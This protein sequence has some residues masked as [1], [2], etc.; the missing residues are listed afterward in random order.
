MKKI[1][2]MLLTAV[3]LICN[4]TYAQVPP[5]PNCT[6]DFSTTVSGLTVNFIP[7]YNTDSALI[8]HTWNFGDG[9]SPSNLYSPSHTY[10]GP[11]TYTIVHTIVKRGTTSGT[12]ACTNSMTK[13]VS[14]TAPAPCNLVAYFGW[15]ASPTNPLSINFTNYSTP[16]SANDS[17]SWTFG[18]G[19]TSTAVNPTHTYA[20]PGNY[21]ACIR[22]VQNYNAAGSA[23]CVKEYC[24]IVVVQPLPCSIRASYSY[25]RDQNQSNVVYFNNTSSVTP[26]SLKWS[27]GDGTFSNDPNPAHTYSNSGLYNVCLVIKKGQCVDDTC[28]QIQIQVPN[29]CTLVAGFNATASTANPLSISFT[30]TSNPLASSDS[31]SWSFGDGTYSTDVN[32]THIYQLPGNYNVCV[33]VKKNNTIA[34]SVPCV[35]EYCKVITVSAPPCSVRASFTSLVSNTQSNTITFSNTSTP[36]TGLDSIRWSFG[37][38]TYSTDV[39]PTHTY[40]TSGAYT[41][42]LFVKKGLCYDDTCMVVTVQVPNPCNLTTYFGWTASASNPS[43][44][45]FT[46][47]STPLV[48]GDSITWNFGDG[49]ALSN[50]INPTHIY[51][52]PGNYNVCLRVKKNSSSATT[53][54]CIREYCKIVNV[55]PP[56]CNIRASFTATAGNT[57]TNTITFTNTSTP[58]GVD[59]V[60]WSFGDG[61][62]S[63]DPNPVHTYTASGSY[64]VCMWVKKGLCADDTCGVIQVQVQNPCTLVAYFSAVPST[65]NPLTINFTNNSTPV[66]PGDS[67]IW[68][69]GDGTG[70]FDLNPSHTYSAP[71]NYNVCVRVKK[72]NTISGTAP[73]VKEYCKVISVTAPV[74]NVRA[75]FSYSAI[76]TAPGTLVFTNTSSP[77]GLDSVKWS[78]GDGTYSN[79]MGSNTHTFATSGTYTVCLLAYK[80]TCVDDTC[81]TITVQVPV[82]CNLTAYFTAQA[83]T[84]TP[85]QFYF[86]NQSTPLTAA[87]SVSWTFGDG[88]TSTDVNPVHT[89]PANIGTTVVNYNVCVRVKQFST[90]ASTPPCVREYCRTISVLPQA[91]PVRASFSFVKGTAQTNVV[92][93]TN[94][95]IPAP[96]DSV[97]WSFG[98]GTYSTD[99]NPVHTYAS[100]GAFTVCLWVKK[101]GMCTDDTCTTIQVQV[102]NVCNLSAYFS[103]QQ[104][105]AVPGQFSFTNLS[106]PLSATDSVT[107]TFGDG[108]TSNDV[109]PTHTYP[110]SMTTVATY[111]VCLRVKQNNNTGA[112]PCV[113]EFCKTIIVQPIP[114]TVHAGYT[115]VRDAAQT[116]VITFTN[117][118]SPAPV[119]SVKW[120]FGDGTYSTDPN[121]VHTYTNSG[122]YNVC[123]WVKKNGMCASDTCGQIQVQVPNPCTLNTYFGWVA[124]S[125]NPL[126]INFTNYSTPLVAGDSVI[127]NFG[128]GSNSFDVNPSHTYN[129][130]GTYNVCLRVKKNSSTPGTAPCDKQYC[131]VVVVQQACNY[132]PDFTFT[133]DSL[134]SAPNTYVFTNST[135]PAGADSLYWNFGDG[136]PVVAGTAGVVT[137]VYT[138]AGTYNACLFVKRFSTL[139]GVAPCMKEV[140][141]TIVVSVQQTCNYVVNYS[142]QADTILTNKIYFTNLSQAT[143]N[144]AIA[145][146]VFGDGSSSNSWNASHTYTQSGT[147]TVCLRVATST[148]CVRE[149]CK[150]IT[151]TVPVNPCT[152]QPN[153]TWQLDQFNSSRVLFNNTTPA[154]SGA[155]AIWNFGDGKTDTSW[156][157]THTYLQPG[158][159]YVCLRISVGANCVRYKCDSVTVP[160]VTT[161]CNSQSLFTSA[162]SASNN[163]QFTF[164]PINQN[165]AATYTWTFGD[166]TGSNDMIAQHQYTQSGAYR[167]CLTVSQGTSCTS[168]TCRYVTVFPA[169]NCDSVKLRYAYRRDTYMRNKV[170]FTALSNYP[171]AQQSWTIS[172]I[173]STGTGIVLNQA[174]PVYQFTDTGR[175]LVC[176]TATYNPNCIKTYCDTVYINSITTQ[177]VL[178]AYPNPAHGAVTVNL[179]LTQPTMIYTYIYNSQNVLVG[180]VA[181]QGSTGNNVV[182]INVQSLVPGFYNLRFVYGNR[183]CY[184]KFQK[185]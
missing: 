74:C 118:S 44:I 170:Y 113:R 166:G 112:A 45:N 177:C 63:T 175:Y 53:A 143:P 31:V 20:A 102:P 68:N 73:C 19:T 3:A 72:N 90:S 165:S 97:K 131:K 46:N 42:C 87:D 60:K 105:T 61:T 32:P 159:Y 77:V 54:P 155:T 70:S 124:S 110:V 169:F 158:R 171:I 96:V 164:T 13:L 156:N 116:N 62:Y 9:S 83:S 49:S 27:F 148:T 8:T 142:W 182:T 81:V 114:C 129:A 135:A 40:T 151:V 14:I 98:D 176:L 115:F 23:P 123:L 59:S 17:V 37:D 29:P 48:A 10:A 140:C 89:F 111:N 137:H 183:I 168:T 41:V 121:P 57:Q 149:E 120:S 163:K 145:T 139:T 117:T 12:V 181:Q 106:T 174:N 7:A 160:P 16:F 47:Y 185:L 55:L 79:A 103:V 80:G 38:G 25:V 107:W 35:R 144:T 78:F 1:L 11:G 69:F 67:V 24:K 18:D 21:N 153:Y 130:P 162:V 6:A 109:N 125:T 173:P 4:S 71:G 28:S 33:R 43:Q 86:Q 76:N 92:T 178:Q 184:S 36:N 141:K 126:L 101:N 180:Q 65:A 58:T 108:T 30:N 22:V 152:I 136:S 91:C 64:T 119:D 34:G 134:A 88:T 133:R 179:N 84:A 132:V 100:S 127:W 50:D 51:A 157:T 75:S 95:S 82:P 56:A 147:Y 93:F 154:L 99:P 26:D 52:A 172:R 146:W 39:N 138:A 122:L 15:V 66:A 104:S 2:A 161:N 167:V 128:D 5:S 94:T 150:T 85:G